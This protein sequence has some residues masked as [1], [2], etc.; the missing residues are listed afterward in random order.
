MT[1]TNQHEGLRAP[2]SGPS[3][4]ESV[5]RKKMQFWDRSKFLIVLVL[6]YLILTW[7]VMADFEG[8]VTFPEAAQQIAYAYQWIFWLLGA[9]VLRQLHFFV[10]EHWSAYHRFWSQ[11]VF[12]GFERW[13]HRR[14]DDWT[15]FRLARA[16]KI[17]FFITLTALVLGAVLDV[18]PFAALL[19]APALIWQALPFFLQIV[20]LFF[21]V[22]IQ[23]VGLFWFLSRGGVETYFPD[24]IKTRF[25]DVW[26]QDHVVERVQENIVFLERPDEIERR[27]GYVPSGLLLWGPPG[28]GKTLMAEAVAGETGKPYVFVDPGA[29]TNMFM[30]VGILKVKGLF[31]KLRKLALRYGGVIVFFDEADSL[32]KRG[33][34][35]QQGPPGQGGGFSEFSGHHGCHGL[36][37]LTEE[38]RQ[39]LAFRGGHPA[40]EEPGRRNRFFMGGGMNGSGDPGTL[41]A[42]LTELSGLKKP[43]GFF[44]RLV[45]RLLGMRPKPPPKYRILV[46]MATNRPD[47]LDEALLRP[48]RID[49]IYK[50][51]YPS[52][53]GR[54]RTYQGYFDKVWH[55]LTPEQIDKLATI[56]PYATGATIKD[57]VNES[58][59]TAIRDGREIITWSD[60]LRAKRLKQL[61]PPEDVEYIERERHA[62]AVHEACHAV[63]A[64]VT[65]FH[66][67]IDI[68]TIE[69]GADYLGMVAS[70]KPED[71]FTR[72]KSEHEAD[73]MV[74]LASLAGERMFFG[75][76]NSS[77][78]SGDLY[79]ATYLTAMME[80]YWG[81]GSGVTSLPALQELEIMG[82][83]A[84]RK[85]GP[86]GS[87]G[88]TDREPA[89][90]QPDLTPDVLG[91]RIEFNL[92]RLLEKTEAL[93][94]EHRREVLCLAHALE[95]HKTLNGDDVVAIIRREPGPL[96]DG[97]VYAS[98]ELYRELE[99][100]HRDAA[101]AHKEH[102]HI[103]R[104]LPGNAGERVEAVPVGFGGSGLKAAR[105]MPPGPPAVIQ[106]HP[107]IQPPAPYG[108]PLPAGSP[109]SPTAAGP[110][111]T[112]GSS[113]V[114][115][116][117]SVA[118]D[119]PVVHDGSVAHDRPAEPADRPEFVPWA[120][121]APAP[122]SGVA[123]AAATPVPVVVGT[124][125]PAAA[126]ARRRV[127]GRIWLVVASLLGLVVLSIIAALA[128]TGTLAG[129]NGA[130]VA[131]SSPVAS[132]GLLLLLFVVIV[133][134]IVGG[135]LAFVAIKGVRAAQARA[136][137]ERD[138]ANA[139][140]QLLA[141]AM[142]P[143]KAMRLLGYDGNGNGT[144]WR[145]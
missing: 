36:S 127:V 44:N 144:D 29:F 142:E 116:D 34:L 84:M 85:R 80:S 117:G 46:M 76:D 126:P 22:I 90:N 128:V 139:R 39:V 73:I 98:D 8:V 96:I 57:L 17:A 129:G 134:A 140:A 53:A 52:K 137:Q 105:A 64:Y 2:G 25:R 100:Y 81:M 131:G 65:R 94:Q 72:W 135:G 86:G 38:T 118:H 71:Q 101:R 108:P 4:P 123:P 33:R 106:G 136:E 48:G 35:A 143:D 59:I 87:I 70:I 107:V 130:N 133:A 16:L 51:G 5:T 88:I 79:S 30:G 109:A 145:A 18:S 10:S 75:E 89:R 104:D 111:A 125:A 92:V 43:R 13:T 138:T 122:V 56:T 15:R 103:E 66:L 50:V 61:G 7:K 95:T 67:E 97:T 83:K 23:F 119:G 54:V 113:P 37:Y 77:G 14:F 99:D 132:P 78:V 91:E 27:G 19:Q 121:A 11:K 24:D 62:V 6:A 49:R 32:G 82:G 114:A 58:L 63:V 141:A 40:E 124:P 3:D 26:G 110:P 60:V 31:R 93:L 28:T 120:A 9:E 102:S 74:S 1:T 112:G 12:G 55:E 41:Q 42:L 68:A 20:F 45:R 47:A 115:H 21:F 69:K